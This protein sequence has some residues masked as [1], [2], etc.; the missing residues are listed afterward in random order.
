MSNSQKEYS[1]EK[2]GIDKPEK[3]VVR[4]LVK[5]YSRLSPLHRGVFVDAP[6]NQVGIAS[7]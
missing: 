5:M 7:P 4:D 1:F 3:E 6:S 2:Y